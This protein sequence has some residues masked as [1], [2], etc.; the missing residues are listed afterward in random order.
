MIKSIEDNQTKID[1]DKNI[2]EEDY[3]SSQLILSK[4]KHQRYSV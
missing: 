4:S 1:R 2:E 3:T